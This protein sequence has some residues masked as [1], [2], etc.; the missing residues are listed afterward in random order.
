MSDQPAD[1]GMDCQ[2]YQ[3]DQVIFEEGDPAETAY[4]IRSGAVLIVKR[5][6]GGDAVLVKL[7]PS[8]AFGELAL[9]DGSP[10]SAAAI[11]AERTELIVIPAA[12][13]HSKMGALDPF[14]RT[15][16]AF[17]KHRILDL[18]SRMVE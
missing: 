10:R 6:P 14:M 5:S 11:A 4:M 8:Q 13:F 12:K 1:S 18:S 16:V 3:A 15:W 7:G 2:V 17:L 9:I